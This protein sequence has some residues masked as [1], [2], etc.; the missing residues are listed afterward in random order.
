MSFAELQ[1]FST[2]PDRECPEQFGGL[3]SVFPAKELRGH[4]RLGYS[5]RPNAC[6]DVVAYDPDVCV[7]GDIK[8]TPGAYDIEINA[9]IGVIQTAINCSLGSTEDELR[10]EVREALRNNLERAI[11]ADFVAFLLANATPSGGPLEAKCVL[12]EA[13]QFLNNTGECGRGLIVGPVNWFSQLGDHIV[14]NQAKGYHHDYL[15]NI[16]IPHSVDNDTVFALDQAVDVKVSDV[17]LMDEFAPGIRIVNDRIMRAEQLYT[18]AVDSCEI[19]SFTVSACCGCASGGGGGGGGGDVN[20]TNDPLNVNVVN[21]CDCVQDVNIASQA[22]PLD[23]N[24]V[25]PPVAPIVLQSEARLLAPGDSWTIADATGTLTSVTMTVLTGT[26]TLTDSNGTVS[27]GLPAG[28]TLVW[29]AQ[30]ENSIVP[31]Q[32]VLADAASTVIV[33]WTQ[34]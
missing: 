26:S 17:L 20:V 1:D 31:P 30:D 29:N 34:K 9:V 24:V 2:G 28:L 19:A 3:L 15:G 23:V 33:N 7:P 6:L 11:E 18:I 12:A 21:T 32:S 14:W 22:G 8:M 4:E 5:F 25:T 13:A 27:A 16:V 10:E